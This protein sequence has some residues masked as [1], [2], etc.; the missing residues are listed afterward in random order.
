MLDAFEELAGVLGQRAVDARVFVVGGAAMVLAYGQRRMTRDVDAIFEPKAEVY[1]A[2][3]DVAVSRN[4]PEDWLNDAAKAFAPGTDPKQRVVLHT[5]NLE[6]SVASPEY[7]L[8][9]KLLAS[10]VDQDVDDIRLLY[11]LLGYTT[12]AEGLDLVERYYP[13]EHLQLRIQ[14]LLEE[15]FDE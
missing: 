6:V 10:R 14:F 3:H 8:A 2:A 9:M 13:R 5:E 7:L 1:A 4:L 15:L 12:A 11:S